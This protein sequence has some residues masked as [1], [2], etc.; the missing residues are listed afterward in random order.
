MKSPYY[1]REED[2]SACRYHEYKIGPR[3]IHIA[4]LITY[5]RIFNSIIS[6]PSIYQVSFCSTMKLSQ[7]LLATA[8]FFVAPTLGQDVAGYAVWD[9]GGGGHQ[10]ATLVV[11]GGCVSFGG[12]AANGLS[13]RAGYR[14][15]L[16]R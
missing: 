1:V 16:Y 10:V 15:R 7:V 3:P 12:A 4:L 11:N 14:C 2:Q 5:I 6:L 9:E 13:V 8:G